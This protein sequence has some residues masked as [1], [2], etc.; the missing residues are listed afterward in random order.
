MMGAFII[1]LTIFFLGPC[2]HAVIFLS[3]NKVSGLS[4]LEKNIIIFDTRKNCF[5]C[6]NSLEK[7]DLVGIEQKNIN[8]NLSVNMMR[9]IKGPSESTMKEIRHPA[10]S[11]QH[12]GETIQAQDIFTNEIVLVN[13]DQ[14]IGKVINK[15]GVLLY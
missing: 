15:S 1:S 10:S 14:I 2:R 6:L 8:G 3:T 12:V 5:N 9:I 13:Q 4:N 11:S 7:G